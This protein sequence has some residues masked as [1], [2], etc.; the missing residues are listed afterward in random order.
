MTSGVGQ[1][2]EAVAA[3]PEQVLTLANAGDITGRNDAPESSIGGESTCI[4]CMA[5]QKI[6]TLPCR[7]PRPSQSS[8]RRSIEAQTYAT[9]TIQLTTANWPVGPYPRRARPSPG[10]REDVVLLVL[11]IILPPDVTGR[12]RTDSDIKF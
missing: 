7:A 3:S 11:R 1:G 10:D 2:A 12:D 5:R 8:S 6:R 4:V 9:G